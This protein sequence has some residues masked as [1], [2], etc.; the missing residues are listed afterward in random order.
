MMTDM[1]VE[2]AL[3]SHVLA[4]PQTTVVEDENNIV[5]DG[6]DDAAWVTLWQH[7]KSTEES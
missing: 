3:L 6:V 4:V 5:L 2:V 1:A 7:S